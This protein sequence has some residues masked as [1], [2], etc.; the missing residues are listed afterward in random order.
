MLDNARK[1]EIEQQ[2]D[3]ILKE[4]DI[5]TPFRFDP[6][7]F[8]STRYGFTIQSRTY[9]DA[10]VTGMLLVDDDEPLFDNTYRLITINSNVINGVDGVK[11]ACFIALHEFGHYILHKKEHRQ[12]AK[13]DTSC[14]ENTEELEA[15]YFALCMLLPRSL[16][17]GYIKP[18]SCDEERIYATRRLFGVTEKKAILRL[19]ELELIGANAVYG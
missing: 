5:T 9:N 11:R 15:D 12:F 13:R 19:E 16:V 2:A 17:E 6:I 7:R 14:K 4:N 8:L 3:R 18:Y 10:D 1:K